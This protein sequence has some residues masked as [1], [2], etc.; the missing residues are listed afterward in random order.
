M[1]SQ[2]IFDVRSKGKEFIDYFKKTYLDAG[3]RFPK[4]IWNH[5]DNH[6]D[7][8]NNRVEGDNNRMKN[9]WGAANP[10]IDKAAG[11]SI[12]LQ[13]Y[14]L[15]ARD[16]YL[17]AKIKN[18]RAPFQKAEVARREGDFRLYRRLHRKGELT[19][20]QYLNNILDLNKFVPKKKYFE[21]LEDTGESDATS[22]SDNSE[23]DTQADNL[24]ETDSH[25]SFSTIHSEDL[26]DTDNRNQASAQ[27]QDQLEAENLLHWYS[28]A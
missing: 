23:D 5:W 12:L 3:V 10:N 27:I 14:E 28:P 16:K 18:A 11:L 4:S 20:Q 7:R 21:P 6:D 1:L 17:N 19:F 24:S 15:D 25:E 13:I 22:I 8:T 9:F 26:L 2:D